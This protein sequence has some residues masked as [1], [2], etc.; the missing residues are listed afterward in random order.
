MNRG[1]AGTPPDSLLDALRRMEAA[2]ELL[3]G[4]AAPAEIGARIDLAICKLR[5]TIEKSKGA[6]PLREPE[7]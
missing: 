6:A 1:P 5:A 3:D 2:L 7:P 4:A